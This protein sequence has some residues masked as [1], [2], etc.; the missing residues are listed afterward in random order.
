MSKV[1]KEFVLAG[2]ATFTLEVP[3]EY[4]QKNDLKP[5][6]TF[7]VSYKP[8]SKQYREAY[9]VSLLTGPDNT[10]SYSYLGMLDKESGK[11]RTTAKSVLDQEHLVTRLLNRALA[12]VWLGD[13]KP[14]EEKG[15]GLH[16]E[17]RCGRCGRL[18][19]TP[20]SIERGIG[21]ECW[22]HMHGGN[23]PHLVAQQEL[24]EPK[25]QV[26]LSQE[27]LELERLI[28]ESE[29]ADA[30]DEESDDEP[31]PSLEAENRAL[32]RAYTRSLFPEGY[33][34]YDGRF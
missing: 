34:P 29:A 16:H 3:D 28:S 21:P 18:L 14:L 12:L 10:R 11:V 1:T 15:F 33:G 23:Y 19:T 9:F 2:K 31:D 6:Y 25:P 20:E 26:G 27:D 7:R 32:S 13:V 17:G 30:R 8:A 5:H 22:T 24:E 4:R